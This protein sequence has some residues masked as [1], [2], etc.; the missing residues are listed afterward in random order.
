[1]IDMKVEVADSY[2][3]NDK[4]NLIYNYLDTFHWDSN[5]NK[6]SLIKPTQH[7]EICSKIVESML[8][9]WWLIS[10]YDATLLTLHLLYKLLPVHV[11]KHSI[12][13]VNPAQLLECL[14]NEINKSNR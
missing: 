13:Y 10:N 7:I 9:Q 1:M 6:N 12:T 2:N 14:L 8:S 11:D 4:E 5:L 3:T